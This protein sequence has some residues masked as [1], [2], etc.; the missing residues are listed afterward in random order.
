MR[1]KGATLENLIF[2]ELIKKGK[3]TYYYS[4]NHECDFLITENEGVSEAIQVCHEISNQD[5]KNREERGLLDASKEFK[6]KKGFIITHSEEL[7][8]KID[9]INIEVIPAYKFMLSD[10]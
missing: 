7:Q 6:L 2:L 10:R 1:D 8:Y 3:N 4:S 5:T 9:G